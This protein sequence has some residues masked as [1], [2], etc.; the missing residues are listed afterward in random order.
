MK[1]IA[2]HGTDSKPFQKFCYNRIGERI[3]HY[4]PGFYF[5]P[6]VIAA[7]QQ[8]GQHVLKA[9]IEINNP[10]IA[11]EQQVDW[12]ILVEHFN[13]EDNT[14]YEGLNMP[15]EEDDTDDRK[16]DQCWGYYL[17]P[18]GDD[19]QILK[20]VYHLSEVT[21]Y[22]RYLDVVNRVLGLDGVVVESD[23]YTNDQ[24]VYVAWFNRQIKFLHW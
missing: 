19:I 2:Y 8:Y 20:D 6:N 16:W 4:G 3:I 13:G 21:S 18:S 7:A 11:G 15:F 12:R 9:S 22:E 17:G 14:I 23:P 5:T 24:P 1:Y 10:I